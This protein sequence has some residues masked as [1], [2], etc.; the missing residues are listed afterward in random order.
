MGRPPIGKV[1]MTGAERVRRFRAKQRP[2]KPETKRNETGG[3]VGTAEIAALKRQLAQAHKRIAELEQPRDEATGL[4]AEN[5]ALQDEVIRL[6]TVLQSWTSVVQS[7]ESGIMR[8]VNFKLIRSCLHP[9][10]RKSASDEKL[11]KA[12]RIFNRL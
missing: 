2:D 10:S 1:A 9:D 12:F 8:L 11:A 3:A 6:K 5:A 7:R 4:Q